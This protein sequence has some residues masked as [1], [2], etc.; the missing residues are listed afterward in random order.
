MSK[1]VLI[2]MCGLPASGKSTYS[3]WLAESG[4]FQ[5]VCPDLIRKDLYGDENVQGDGK[6]VFSIA[7]Y[8]MATIGN[9]RGNVVFDATNI[10][11][12]T[13]TDLVKKMR[14]HFDIIIC[15]WFSTPLLTCKLRNA[16]RER[17]VPY[18]V[19]E[20]MYERFRAPMLDEGFDIVEEIKNY[21]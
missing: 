19:L 1:N 10:D 15:K 13:R 14:P 12:K 18:E 21:Y 2:V 11:R 4:I 8:Q 9:L 16:K 3:Q 6:K 17:Q 20:S 5:R 7:H